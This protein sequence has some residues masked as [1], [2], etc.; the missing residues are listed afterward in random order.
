MDMIR[1][2]IAAE[3][4]GISHKTLEKL[5]VTGNGPAYYK[6][7]AVVVYDTKDLDGWLQDKRRTS[8]SDEGGAVL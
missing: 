5:A 7:G 3:Y 2:N 6:I 8:T 1:R 4:L